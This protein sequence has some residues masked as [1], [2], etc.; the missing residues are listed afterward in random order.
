MSDGIQEEKGRWG[1]MSETRRSYVVSDTRKD[2]ITARLDARK[3]PDEGK[4]ESGALGEGCIWK[5]DQS[6]VRNFP[7]NFN[8]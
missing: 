1:E 5:I 2:W 4:G 7:L 3:L 8:S 6:Y